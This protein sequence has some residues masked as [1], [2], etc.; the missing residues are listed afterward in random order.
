MVKLCEDNGDGEFLS[1][2]KDLCEKKEKMEYK[3]K[4]EK[5]E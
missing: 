5:E 1:K 3:Y 4:V 2:I